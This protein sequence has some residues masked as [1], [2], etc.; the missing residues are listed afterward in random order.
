MKRQNKC[1]FKDEKAF[2]LDASILSSIDDRLADMEK[3]YKKATRWLKRKM[4]ERIGYKSNSFYAI[5]NELT[6][7]K[8]E[9]R[10]Y[11]KLETFYRY[12]TINA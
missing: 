4:Q 7:S 8:D 12:L 11:R 6:P 5:V 2:K 3:S 10:K 1:M 9:L